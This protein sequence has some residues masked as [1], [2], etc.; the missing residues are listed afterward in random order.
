ML[1]RN[2]DAQLSL[3][4]LLESNA[5]HEVPDDALPADELH[6]PSSD[7]EQELQSLSVVP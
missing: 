5:M 7:A 4:V 6:P 2:H 1:R 3:G